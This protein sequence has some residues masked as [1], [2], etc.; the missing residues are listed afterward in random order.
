M[1]D[2]SHKEEYVKE[3]QEKLEKA[4][5]VVLANCE[6]VTVSEMTELR[7]NVRQTNSELRVVKNTLLARAL[8]N[9]NMNELEGHMKGATAVTFGYEDQIAPVKALYE[10]TQKAKKFVFKAGF[11]DGKA[12]TVDQLTA[13]S[14]IPGRK[15]LLSMLASAVQGPIRKLACVLDALRTKREEAEGGPAT[16]AADA[17]PA[18]EAAP[19]AE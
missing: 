7:R 18:E 1:K 13:L 3:F 10:F 9:A 4:N 19:A 5:I 8:H 11:M 15:D 2:I 12:L 17:A 6:G 14:K 16:P